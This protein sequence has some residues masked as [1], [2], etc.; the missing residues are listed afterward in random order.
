MS[1]EDAFVADSEDEQDTARPLLLKPQATDSVSQFTN[2][3]SELQGDT[4]TISN[5][6]TAPPPRPRPKPRP[7]KRPTEDSS[8]GQDS[9]DPSVDESKILDFP[10]GTASTIADRAKTRARNAGRNPLFTTDV[11]DMTLSEDSLDELD[12]FVQPPKRRTPPKTSTS[13]N[14]DKTPVTQRTTPRRSSPPWV[15]T[16]PVSSQPPRIETISAQATSTT[17]SQASASSAGKRKRHEVDELAEDE[18]LLPPPPTF[19]AA[20]TPLPEEPPPEKAA[21]P[22]LSREPSIEAPPVKKRSRKKAQDD[23]DEDFEVSVATKKK[24]RAKKAPKEKAPPKEKVPKQKAPKKVK[25]KGKEKA[26]DSFKSAETIIDS[27]DEGGGGMQ[28]GDLPKNPSPAAP[29]AETLEPPDPPILAPSGSRTAKKRSSTNA[30]LDDDNGNPDSDDEL[31]NPVVIIRT[32]PRRRTKKARI[33]SDDEADPPIDNIEKPAS[34]AP[35][36][37]E[38][39]VAPQGKGKKTKTKAGTA[40]KGRKKATPPP[41]DAHDPE[42][43]KAPPAEVLP[44]KENVE[45]TPEG[46]GDPPL[47]ETRETTPTAADP[48]AAPAGGSE[49]AGQ[50]VTPKYAS[51]TSR[52][53]VAP[54]T[55]ST[56]MSELIKRVNSSTGSSRK[57]FG[58]TAYSPYLKASRSMLS[59]IAPLHPNRRTP[60]PPLPPP[61]PRKKTKKELEMEERWEEELVESVGGVTEWACMTDDERK[62]ARKLKKEREMA[63]WE[64]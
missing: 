64:D 43:F 33:D 15:P 55:K 16:E 36:P 44:P 46:D 39:E 5:A 8:I 47:P 38:E 63:G 3:P 6:T 41:Q 49:P 7:K 23:D 61:P 19:F 57:S 29:S 53:S 20:P 27:G 30:R 40:K 50:P 56:P 11:I 4:S 52:Y 28:L 32:A 13:S 1:D 37:E 45:P 9:K 25:G 58:G 54:R 24:P 12:T 42:D 35:A 48:D 34:E 22:A 59:K 51:L 60:P 26:D 10:S 18:A 21:P 14:L 31:G 2:P 62:E 17:V